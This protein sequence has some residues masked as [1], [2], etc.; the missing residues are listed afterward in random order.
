[1]KI[2]LEKIEEYWRHNKIPIRLR[3]T[4]LNDEPFE[5]THYWF[6]DN[7]SNKVWINTCSITETPSGQKYGYIGLS[8]ESCGYEVIGLVSKAIVFVLNLLAPLNAV[9][10]KRVKKITEDE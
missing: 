1:V 4:M 5:T 3:D 9:R 7:P 2:I 8:S 10:H 6:K